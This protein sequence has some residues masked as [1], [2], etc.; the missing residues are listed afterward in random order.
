MQAHLWDR[1]WHQMR[2]EFHATSWGFPFAGEFVP[3][4]LWLDFSMNLND[5]PDSNWESWVIEM[6]LSEGRDWLSK[7]ATGLN[8]IISCSSKSIWLTRL[9][10]CQNGSPM[11]RSFWP[12]EQFH[13]SHTFW[14]TAYYHIQPSRKFW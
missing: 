5:S 3:W 13:H 6:L 10:F 9:L 12:K 11:R 1:G 14:T 7:F 2:A 8:M 4:S